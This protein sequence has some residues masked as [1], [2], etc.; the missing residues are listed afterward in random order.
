MKKI[1]IAAAL[2][3][4]STAAFSAPSFMQCTASGTGIKRGTVLI[5]QVMEANIFYATTKGNP[6]LADFPFIV[7]V[8]KIESMK[9]FA[10]TVVQ[11]GTR[12][13]SATEGVDEAVLLVENDSANVKVECKI[14]RAQH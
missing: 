9:T 2:A 4:L 14:L 7:G 13:S 8:T 6:D 12:N 3:C 11:K 1:I 10:I 5:G